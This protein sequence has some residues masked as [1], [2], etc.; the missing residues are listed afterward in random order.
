L[1]IQ[2][3]A[4]SPNGKTL[5]AAGSKVSLWEVNSGRELMQ[6][7][8]AKDESYSAVAFSK[9][10][11]TI[12]VGTNGFVVN[13]QEQEVGVILW[14][15]ES[16]RKLHRFRGHK[17]M[18][19]GVAFGPD[20]TT[21]ASAS[22]DGTIR[23]WELRTGTEL[24]K[25]IEGKTPM[26]RVAFSPD[27][28]LLASG[29]WSGEVAVQELDTSKVVQR[30]AA[31]GHRIR[32]LAFSPQG[33]TLLSG[34]EYSKVRLW[35]PTTG[36]ELAGDSAW[37]RDAWFGAFAP[38]GKSL[39]VW[40]GDHAIHLWHLD[41]GREQTLGGGHRHCML[42]A[43][44]A[45]DGKTIATTSYDGLRIWD[46]ATG[47]ELSEW[48]DKEEPCLWCVAFSP[49]GKAVACGDNAGN[50]I[51]LDA[52][53]GREVRRLAAIEG[54]VDA[55]AFSRDG[56]L[57]YT[58]GS[59]VIEVWDLSKGKAIHQIG[60]LPKSGHLRMPPPVSNLIV[61]P[62]G[63]LISACV[64][65]SVRVWRAA[66][67]EEI[68]PIEGRD[69]YSRLVAFGP[70]SPSLL[71]APSRR[72]QKTLFRW[73]FGG[74]DAM[75]PVAEDRFETVALALALDGKSIASGIDDGR[76][77]L[78]DLA[79]GAEQRSFSNNRTASGIVFFPRG[80]RLLTIN[81]DSTALVWDLES[82]PA[83]GPNDHGDQ[84]LDATVETAANSADDDSADQTGGASFRRFMPDNGRAWIVVGLLMV[85]V[86]IGVI[87][88]IVIR[89]RT[90]SR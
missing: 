18:V 60:K 40:G 32:A 80:D 66:T 59:Y 33:T 31:H 64:L 1:D 22:R 21:L 35:N 65:G 82:V 45:P 3:L 38:N 30:F 68:E 86:L 23:L 26:T 57:L 83:R 90:G 63:R 16:G 4:F 49:D 47:K 2:A 39:A 17:E 54:S 46:A 61:S 28:K 12:A 70:D 13:N 48:H 55:V 11:N 84:Q 87:W 78:W 89:R 5:A 50:A 20:D 77:I 73:S 69:G 6:L 34:A 43:A 19:E 56:T 37:D 9:G 10:G 88:L 24:R 79:T 75:T 51:L 52:T 42:S 25:S 15:V 29:D 14:E 7:K 72:F 36:E 81:G 71:C 62:D 41:K 85:V 8:D 58:A 27:G 74:P 44:V 67:G 53:T 76:I